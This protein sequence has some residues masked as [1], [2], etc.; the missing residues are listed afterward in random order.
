MFLMRNFTHDGEV[1]EGQWI[2]FSVQDSF[3]ALPSILQTMYTP[4]TIQDYLYF[5]LVL[6]PRLRM[7]FNLYLTFSLSHFHFNFCLPFQ[8]KHLLR[9]ARDPEIL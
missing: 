1:L 3:V 2:N 5:S 9:P 4:E 6:T 7:L 8:W